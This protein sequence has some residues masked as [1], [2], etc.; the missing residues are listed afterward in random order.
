MPPLPGLSLASFKVCPSVCGLVRKGTEPPHTLDT[1]A[2]HTYLHTVRKPSHT[3]SGTHPI[4]AYTE[5]TSRRYDLGETGY[6]PRRQSADLGID[7]F[8]S[9]KDL[10]W[11]E[12]LVLQAAASK[13]VRGNMNFCSPRVF[14]SSTTPRLH[15]LHWFFMFSECDYVWCA[16]VCMCGV[17]LWWG[18]AANVGCLPRGLSSLFIAVECC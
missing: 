14:C 12:M 3:H 2:P 15:N 5:M 10:K 18:P 9:P 1:P 4:T 8:F 17:H 13:C 16:Y 11:V 7:W 6:E